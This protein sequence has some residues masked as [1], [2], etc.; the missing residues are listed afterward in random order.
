MKEYTIHHK[1]F[2]GYG[3]YHRDD[4]SYVVIWYYK[5]EKSEG[6][7]KFDISYSTNVKEL[8]MRVCAMY[9]Q[10]VAVEDIETFFRL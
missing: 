5:G 7:L 8:Y 3:T 2:C 1:K 4:G 10:G 9:D 6:Q